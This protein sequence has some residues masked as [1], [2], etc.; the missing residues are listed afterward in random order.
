MSLLREK[1]EYQCNQDEIVCK[2]FK[3]AS[4]SASQVTQMENDCCRL[5]HG[6][7]IDC[8]IY[9][10]EYL[11]TDDLITVCNLDDYFKDIIHN[12]VISKHKL[13]FDARQNGSS[14]ESNGEL[15][16]SFEGKIRQISYFNTCNVTEF[17]RKIAIH[18]PDGLKDLE[19]NRIP[20]IGLEK[21][22][23]CLTKSIKHFQATAHCL[24]DLERLVLRS[25]PQEKILYDIL[26]G[27]SAIPLIKELSWISMLD[28]KE[29][30]LIHLQ[31]I[32]EECLIEFLRQ[33][34]RLE[35]FVNELSIVDM[36]KVGEAMAN[37]C[38]DQIRVFRD[39]GSYAFG[40]IHREMIRT[41]Y[42]FLSKFTNLKEVAISSFYTCGCDLR[43]PID[44]LSQIESLKNLA[45]YRQRTFDHIVGMTTEIVRSN[46]VF[47]RLKQAN[48][49]RDIRCLIRRD[50]WLTFNTFANLKSLEI[51]S[52][53]YPTNCPRIEFLI[54]YPEIIANVE[55]VTVSG[56]RDRVDFFEF[57]ASVPKL[58][59]L[60]IHNFGM[61]LDNKERAMRPIAIA[62]EI[63]EK[64]KN[65]RN[66]ADCTVDS[67]DI[68][69]SEKQWEILKDIQ[70][71]DIAIKFHIKELDVHR[72]DWVPGIAK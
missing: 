28:L 41:R 19:I 5:K 44:R 27:R 20:R 4:I 13:V 17:I 68:F 12:Y 46:F 36:K 16:Q 39:Q 34:P 63:L 69:V 11:N 2:K 18:C 24:R 48:F 56:W 35:H 10:F 64:R 3:M 30:H 52:D 43:Y 9:I 67:M 15:F 32:E 59:K 22:I 42:D 26:L 6:L 29:L 1:R 23:N 58:R 33:R 31:N 71:I 47:E 7:N 21:S 72:D 65:E 62:A 66:N 53:I 50:D 8:L 25:S 14:I 37:Y 49:Y 57:I 70:G 38:G 61:K 45:I 40:Y 55:M 51:N 54:E 60:S